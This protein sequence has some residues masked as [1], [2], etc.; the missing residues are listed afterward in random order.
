MALWTPEGLSMDAWYDASNSDSLTVSSGYVSQWNDIS[1]NNRHATSSGASRP[2]L[3]TEAINSKDAI[4]FVNPQYFN[5]SGGVPLA[6]DMCTFMVFTR[7]S[8]GIV[9]MILGRAP[10][11]YYRYP[12]WWDSLNTIY[13]RHG[14]TLKTVA[15]SQTNTGT[16]LFVSKRDST[17]EYVWRNGAGVGTVTTSALDYEFNTIGRTLNNSSYQH[18]GYI[19]EI[20]FF[21]SAVSVDDRQKIEGYL[22]WKWGVTLT[23]S[24]PYYS[25][26]PSIPDV[27]IPK[28]YV[29]VQQESHRQVALLGL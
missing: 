29:P 5:I 9:S 19:A 27:I 15:S 16:L 25:A 3:G 20:L 23:G 26:A 4:N 28:I 22:A 2:T 11:T 14:A 17:Y 18:N 12:L 21:A 8:T 6:N 13:A 1:G 7:A 24:H 10:P